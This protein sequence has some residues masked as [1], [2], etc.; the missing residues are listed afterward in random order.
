MAIETRLICDQRSSKFGFSNLYRSLRLSWLSSHSHYHTAMAMMGGPVLTVESS[1]SASLFL[2]PQRRRLSSATKLPLS[3][4]VSRSGSGVKNSRKA[5]T[6][7][8]P[9]KQTGDLTTD[10]DKSATGRK[11]KTASEGATKSKTPKTHKK[12]ARMSIGTP[13]KA[14]PMDEERQQDVAQRFVEMEVSEVYK[15]IR[16]QTGCLGGNA[17]GGA[18]YGEITQSSFQRIVDYMKENCELSASSLFLDVGSGLGKPNFHVAIDPGC[19]VSYGIELED[20]RWQLSLHNLKSVLS[21][22]VNKKKLNRTVFTAGDITHART[23]NPFSHIYSFDVGFPPNVMDELAVIFNRS[24]A[25]YFASFHSP[26]KVIDMY[27]FD[28]ENIGRIATSMAGSSEGHTCYFYSRCESPESV[29]KESASTPVM[30]R[31]PTKTEDNNDDE[32]G[33]LLHIDPLFRPGFDV[34]KRG[35]DGVLAWIVSFFGEEVNTSRTRGQKAKSLQQRKQQERPL[36]S[37]YRV[38]GKARIAEA[39]KSQKN[40]AVTPPPS[41]PKRSS[42][43]LRL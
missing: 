18:I 27:G 9:Q 29:K 2:T 30:K 31:D 33:A 22:D 40:K 12:R 16:K 39:V 28:V 38:V 35:R 6:M 7:T 4:S 17:A 13:G 14:V 43:K 25:R 5:L 26:R 37:Y 21:L 34:L 24:T 32:E 1:P 20:L 19:E 41:A 8:T 36:E 10:G 15:A 23:L 11:R 42:K 3:S